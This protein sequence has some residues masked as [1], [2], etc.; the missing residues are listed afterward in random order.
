M[1]I[2]M[3]LVLLVVVVPLVFTFA[4]RSRTTVKWLTRISES[5]QA[6]SLAE[7]GEARAYEQIRLRS[8]TREG[9]GTASTGEFH[10]WL[11]YLGL[12]DADQAIYVV[13][14]RGTFRGERRCLVSL[15]DASRTGGP[16]VLV[17][18]DRALVPPDA[19]GGD[20]SDIGLLVTAHESRLEDCFARIV[21]ESYTPEDE[22]VTEIQQRV[23]RFGLDELV[24]R[25]NEV[26]PALRQAKIPMREE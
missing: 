21:D 12:G 17:P 10:Y 14:S 24:Q 18:R 15:V 26:D 1:A 2:P 13:A 23:R 22:F 19:I 7:E 4:M 6:L 3:L 11:R 20:G 8:R 16:R 9:E 5:K 25:W